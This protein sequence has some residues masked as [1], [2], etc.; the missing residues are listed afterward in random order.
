VVEDRGVEHPVVTVAP[1]V[2][3]EASSAE[4]GSYRGEP[5]VKSPSHFDLRGVQSLRPVLYRTGLGTFGP[6]T[7]SNHPE[8][9][10][11]TNLKSRTR[12]DDWD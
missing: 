5:G 7:T 8:D 4:G 3:L 2:G 1:S 9:C 10:Q 6:A 11:R 12:W